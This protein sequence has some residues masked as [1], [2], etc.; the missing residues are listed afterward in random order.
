ME[1][2]IT[3]QESVLKHFA[4]A[5]SYIVLVLVIGSGF[6]YKMYI[7]HVEKIAAITAAKCGP[8]K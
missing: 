1:S 5:A 3:K 6:G 8:V 2:Y 4:E 7:D